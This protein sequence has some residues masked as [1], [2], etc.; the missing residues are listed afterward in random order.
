MNM[1][2]EKRECKLGSLHIRRL[3][4]DLTSTKTTW[5]LLLLFPAFEYQH[6]GILH[7]KALTTAQR[8]DISITTALWSASA[9]FPFRVILVYL[10]SQMIR[11]RS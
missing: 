4:R 10:L 2:G 6:T 5:S 8:H 11:N 9:S 3:E 7:S 1:D